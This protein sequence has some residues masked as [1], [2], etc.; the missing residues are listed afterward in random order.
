MLQYG[1]Y[2]EVAEHCPSVLSVMARLAQARRVSEADII[3]LHGLYT[4]TAKP[5]VHVIRS[6]AFIGLT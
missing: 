3:E 1:M 4:S 5:P 6:P 2:F